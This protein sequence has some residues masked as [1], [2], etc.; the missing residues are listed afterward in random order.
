[1]AEIDEVII[2]S[3]NSAIVISLPTELFFIVRLEEQEYLTKE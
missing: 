3:E 1:M 2:T